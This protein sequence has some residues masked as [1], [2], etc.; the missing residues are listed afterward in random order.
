MRFVE[1]WHLL[2]LQNRKQALHLHGW[3]ANS[4]HTALPRAIGGNDQQQKIA[5]KPVALGLALTAAYDA[6]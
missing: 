3:T 2:D 1:Q 6:A 4:Y 5:K